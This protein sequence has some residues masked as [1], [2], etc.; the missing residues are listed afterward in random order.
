VR[1]I[2][3][4]HNWV[5]VRLGVKWSQVPNPV[6]PTRDFAVQRRSRKDSGAALFAFTGR[7]P[8]PSRS[9]PPAE[10]MMIESKPKDRMAEFG[11]RFTEGLIT[12]QHIAIH[13]PRLRPDARAR[14]L[15]GDAV[16]I[17]AW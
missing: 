16:D 1:H 13:R 4:Q 5:D 3:G 15:P 6:S 10:A 17:V 2:A 9:T 11:R 8:T 14:E 12:M 7:T